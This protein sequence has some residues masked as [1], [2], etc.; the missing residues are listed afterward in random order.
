MIK[1]SAGQSD[2]QR[3]SA[4]PSSYRWGVFRP[5]PNASHVCFRFK[6][7]CSR[8]ALKSSLV[9]GAPNVLS[10]AVSARRLTSLDGHMQLMKWAQGLPFSRQVALS[11]EQGAVA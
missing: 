7:I 2:V 10:G 4:L 11:G 8:H 6:P 3:D 9:I 5:K 1:G